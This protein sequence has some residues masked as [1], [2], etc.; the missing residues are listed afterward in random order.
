MYINLV[1]AFLISRNDGLKAVVDQYFLIGGFF[2]FLLQSFC[3]TSL[4]KLYIKVGKEMNRLSN[5]LNKVKQKKSESNNTGKIDSNTRE[6]EV[7]QKYIKHHRRGRK[8]K[9][10]SKRNRKKRIGGKKN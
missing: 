8:S 4:G 3:K 2:L 10:K 5:K 1:N 6:N 9:N 7:L